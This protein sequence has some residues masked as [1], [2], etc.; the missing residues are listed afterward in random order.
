M[1]D[2]LKEI[3]QFYDQGIDLNSLVSLSKT[4]DTTKDRITKIQNRLKIL[5]DNSSNS[6]LYDALS[7]NF[8]V[9]LLEDLLEAVASEI[10]EHRLNVALNGVNCLER[11]F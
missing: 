11:V 1:Q 6:E 5:C 9:R 8:D 3:R 10:Y 7:N 2:G 4:F